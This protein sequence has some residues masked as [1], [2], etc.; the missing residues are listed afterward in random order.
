MHSVNKPFS[1]PA[2]TGNSGDK[3]MT[4]EQ[5][6]FVFSELEREWSQGLDITVQTTSGEKYDY[7]MDEDSNWRIEIGLLILNC[8]DET[9]FIDTDK[10]E[11]INI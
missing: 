2:A 7:T 5:V 11:S 1:P 6:K 4:S 3:I 9:H 10:I 8:D